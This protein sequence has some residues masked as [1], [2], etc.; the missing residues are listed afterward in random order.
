MEIVPRVHAI[1]VIGATA[2][3]IVEDTLTL[4]DAGGITSNSLST[5]VTRP[6]GA[7]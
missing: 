3:L 2:H 7:P 6:A 4:I 5:T 1:R